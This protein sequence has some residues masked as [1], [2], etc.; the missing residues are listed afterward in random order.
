MF[1]NR[2]AIILTV[3]VPGTPDW[4]FR[5]KMSLGQSLFHSKW[6]L[7]GLDLSF[8]KTDS[9]F[10]IRVLARADGPVRCDLQKT[11]QYVRFVNK[12]TLAGSYSY[13]CS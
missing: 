6:A 10:T 8:Q 9:R 5:T 11:K 12:L 7:A 2:L 3:S 13:S 1:L 4:T